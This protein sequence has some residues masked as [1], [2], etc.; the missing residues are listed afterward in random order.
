MGDESANPQLQPRNIVVTGASSGIGSVVAQ[1]LAANGDRVA[2]GARRGD[3]LDAVATHI[4]EDGGEV[5]A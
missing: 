2:I 3:R 1:A 4:R 5:F